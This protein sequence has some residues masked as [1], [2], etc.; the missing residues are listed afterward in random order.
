MPKVNMYTIFFV[1]LLEF[2]RNGKEDQR[3]FI[4]KI[5]IVCNTFEVKSPIRPKHQVLQKKAA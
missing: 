5:L 3:S 4:K 2:A 1:A